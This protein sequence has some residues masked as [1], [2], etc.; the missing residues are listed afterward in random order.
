MSGDVFV[1]SVLLF[2]KSVET[3]LPIS[4]PK[5]VNTPSSAKPIAESAD[6]PMDT[7]PAT[8]TPTISSLTMSF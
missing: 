8:P 3:F 4:L 6:A 2:A 5:T 1:S 7:P